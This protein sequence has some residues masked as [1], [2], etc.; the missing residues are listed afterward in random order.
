MTAARGIR[1]RNPGNINDGSFAQSQRGY[2][3]TEEAGRFATFATMGYGIAALIA[4][5]KVYRKQHK[6]TTVRGIINRWAPPQENETSAYVNAVC[7]GWVLPDEELPDDPQ[8][9]LFLAQR[10]VAHE[11]GHDAKQITQ[12]D[13][14]EAM[15]LSFGTVTAQPA[16]QPVKEKKMPAPFIGLALDA[17]L[18]SIPT[19]IR[20]F[21]KGTR[22]EDNAK[23]AEIVV[24]LAKDAIGAVNEQE[25]IEKIKTD[26]SAVA[27]IDKAMKDNWLEIT[28]VGGGIKEA[29]AFAV[30]M[31][32]TGPLWRQIGFGFMVAILAFA[33][34]IGGGAVMAYLLLK[35]GTDETIVSTILDYYKAVGYIVVG[36]VFGSSA[37]NRKKDDTIA[38]QA[39]AR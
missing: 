18:S 17:L 27:V 7:A 8:T 4:L 24:P 20:H 33:I 25:V 15:Q 39:G 34:V 28:E 5:L 11:N 12:A 10:I 32:G 36:Y 6:L 31:T 37:S 35:T 19:L 3:G 38:A 21:G 22:S 2:S 1:N 26:P 9:Y 14:D 13:W 30:E 16:P 23:L 29:R